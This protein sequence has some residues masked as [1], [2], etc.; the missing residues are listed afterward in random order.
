VK[1]SF[2]FEK[3]ERVASQKLIDELFTGGNSQSVAAFP[4]RAVYMVQQRQA[5]E[6]PAK[7]LIS[8]AKRRLHHAVDRNRTKRQLREAYRLNKHRLESTLPDNEQLVVAFIWLADG[9]ESTDTVAARV[10]SLL[11]RISVKLQTKNS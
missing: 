4:L 11:K 5:D 6:P 7:L 2:S 1:G 9:L 10:K 3:N 8:V